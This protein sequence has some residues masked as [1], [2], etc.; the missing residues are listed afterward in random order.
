VGTLASELGA[1]AGR[2]A[3]RPRV[4]VDAN[5]PAALVAFM[6][7]RLSWDALFVVE[8]DDLRRARDDE[9][10]RTARQLARTLISLD[11]DYLDD[12]RFPPDESGGV[13]VLA[14]PEARGL[15]RLLSR[16][17]AEFFRGPA[18]GEVAPGR[19]PLA[20]RKMYVPV[21]WGGA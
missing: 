2:I 20:G 3:R 15:M 1:H 16:I 7:A 8:H 17:D 5:V 13:L 10:Y 4:Y 18:A 11:R 14:A 6:R 19:P 12:A 9:H 21:D